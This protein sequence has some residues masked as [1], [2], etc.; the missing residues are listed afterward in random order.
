MGAVAR[1]YS[2]TDLGLLAYRSA[3]SPDARAAAAERLD[4]IAAHVVAFLDET[5]RGRPSAML[6]ATTSPFPNVVL[7]RYGPTGSPWGL[8]TA[9]LARHLSRSSTAVQQ[10]VPNLGG[11]CRRRRIRHY[12][13]SETHAD[14]R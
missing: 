12:V 7:T 9:A 11:L 2:V 14:A 3:V 5:L 10:A 1:P 8:P 6:H 13:M 4:I